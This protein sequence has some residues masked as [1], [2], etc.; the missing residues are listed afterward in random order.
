MYKNDNSATGSYLPERFN[1]TNTTGIVQ[2]SPP[3]G[4]TNELSWSLSSLVHAFFIRRTDLR[5]R[6]GS[7]KQQPTSYAG[8][9]CQMRWAVLSWSISVSPH[10]HHFVTAACI[11]FNCHQHYNFLY[12]VYIRWNDVLLFYILIFS[13]ILSFIAVCY[14]VIVKV[15]SQRCLYTVSL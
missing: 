5:W 15:N 2:L 3:E 6:S 13:V 9:Q 14:S 1:H 7:P 11:L 10:R 4:T 8:L 12:R